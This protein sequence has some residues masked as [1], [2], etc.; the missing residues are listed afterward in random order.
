MRGPH[1]QATKASNKRVLPP[2]RPQNIPKDPSL[3]TL[4]K[5]AFPVPANP[6]PLVPSAPPLLPV[7]DNFAEPVEKSRNQPVAIVSGDIIVAY[8][9]G[10][11]KWQERFFQGEALSYDVTQ[12]GYRYICC[13]GYRYR[14]I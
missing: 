11:R 7:H 2:P 13:V 12:W 1:G 10:C 14:Y 8:Q 5:T 4:A 9:S 6:Q 3:P